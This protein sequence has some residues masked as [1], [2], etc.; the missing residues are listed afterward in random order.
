ML[1]F[2]S[3]E[4]FINKVFEIAKAESDEEIAVNSLKRLKIYNLKKDTLITSNPLCQEEEIKLGNFQSAR[5]KEENKIFESLNKGEDVFS[6]IPFAYVKTFLNENYEV[7]IADRFIKVYKDDLA[8]IV[9]NNDYKIFKE[10]T[11]LESIKKLKQ[12]GNILISNSNISNWNKALNYK[13]QEK[14]IS[15]IYSQ[16][17]NDPIYSCSIPQGNIDV[18]E[19][20]NN[21]YRLEVFGYPYNANYQWNLPD[22]SI[23][24]GNP[25][26][27]TIYDGGTIDISII[28]D[29]DWVCTGEVFI[30]CGWIGSIPGSRSGI[31]AGNNRKLEGLLEVFGS[32]VTV[33]ITGKRRSGFQWVSHNSNLSA[34]TDRWYGYRA[35]SGSCDWFTGTVSTGNQLNVPFAAKTISYPFSGLIWGRNNGTSANYTMSENGGQLNLTIFR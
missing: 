33:R 6:L 23:Q 12:E 7:K 34:V 15:N 21:T 20:S 24:Y 9:K 22:G 29:V 10:L 13:I 16:Q 25:I 14:P 32:E 5:K 28:F 1:Y 4:D 11:K 8:L 31:I 17:S 18:E 3:H 26:Y 35:E 2:K 19:L 27:V 30:P